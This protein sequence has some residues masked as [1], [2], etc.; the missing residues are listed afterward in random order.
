MKPLLKRTLILL[1]VGLTVS[2]IALLWRSPATAKLAVA[3][4]LVQFTTTTGCQTFTAPR[5]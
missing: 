2:L 4:P 1:A 3:P 5:V